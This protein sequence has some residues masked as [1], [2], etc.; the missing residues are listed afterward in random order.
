MAKSVEIPQDII[1]NVIA[2]VGDDKR[3]LKQCAL[4][5]SSFLL[6]TRK[7]LFSRITL[8]GEI[9]CQGIHE[10]LIQNP[11]FQSFV[12]TISIPLPVE[13]DSSY[14]RSRSFDWIDGTSLLAILRLPFCCLERISIN[15]YYFDPNPWNWDSFSSELKDALSNIIHSSSLK[16]LS[17]TRLVNVP[18]T[19]FLRTVHFT[20]L[21][22]DSIYDFASENLSS[23]T[24][25]DLKGV[26]PMAS[27]TVIDRCVWHFREKRE[28]V[29]GTSRYSCHS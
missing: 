13:M 12:R 3:L 5:S 19:F 21:E 16:T 14:L 1:D 8:K 25:A 18:M 24:R 29:R 27:Q 2:A 23:L 6:P 4:V 28:R 9:K 11:N 17:L 15:R 7:Q 20:T 10:F 26:A 22:L